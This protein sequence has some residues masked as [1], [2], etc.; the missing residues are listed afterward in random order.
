MRRFGEAAYKVGL[1]LSLSKDEAA[2]RRW[3]QR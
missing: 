1:I 3:S 2:A